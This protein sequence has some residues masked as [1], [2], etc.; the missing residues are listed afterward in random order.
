MPKQLFD[1]TPFEIR[2]AAARGTLSKRDRQTL[3]SWKKRARNSIRFAMYRAAVEG[4]AERLRALYVSGWAR[5]K[6]C[7]ESSWPD[8]PQHTKSFQTAAAWLL[9]TDFSP[10]YLLRVAIDQICFSGRVKYPLPRQLHSESIQDLVPEWVPPE[11]RRRMDGRLP[12]NSVDN[13]D[14]EE[15]A[16]ATEAFLALHARDP[17]PKGIGFDFSKTDQSWRDR[18]RKPQ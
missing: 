12:G 15:A 3:A 6:G 11:D 7:P 2:L 17:F 8:K 10:E 5:T 16:R 18:A 13:V 9:E 14:L 4:V 1:L